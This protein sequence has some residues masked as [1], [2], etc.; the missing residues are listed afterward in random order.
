MNLQTG[1]FG[2]P[3]IL[4]TLIMFWGMMAGQHYPGAAEVKEQLEM[5]KQKQAM[6]QGQNPGGFAPEGQMGKVA[7]M[8]NMTGG[9]MPDGM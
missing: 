1:A 8:M 5:Q 2:D 6:A 3:K 7:D 9:G 4:E